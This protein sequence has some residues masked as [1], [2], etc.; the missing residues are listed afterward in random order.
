MLHPGSL[1]P[2]AALPSWFGIGVL[3]PDRVMLASVGALL[4]LRRIFYEIEGLRFLRSEIALLY[5]TLTR[6]FRGQNPDIRGAKT[7]ISLG[8]IP[9]INRLPDYRGFGPWHSR[10]RQSHWR[11]GESFELKALVIGGEL[12]PLCEVQNLLTF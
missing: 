6:G 4:S 5:Q 3:A 11:T 1:R 9:P 8:A 12:A 10:R 7:P 2:K